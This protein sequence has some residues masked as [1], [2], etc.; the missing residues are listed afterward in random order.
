[1]SEANINFQHSGKTADPH[2]IGFYD[3][4]DSERADFLNI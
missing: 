3:I 4:T 2:T 1:M